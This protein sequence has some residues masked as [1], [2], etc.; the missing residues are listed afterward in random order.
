M[1]DIELFNQE[2]DK[3][4]DTANGLLK[5]WQY[6]DGVMKLRIKFI[7]K[8]QNPNPTYAKDGDS[9]FDLRANLTEYVILEPGERVLIP[10]GLFF[11][12]P[13]NF[14]LQVRSR[15]GLAL[16]N[17]VMVLNSP[18]TVDSGYRGE[19]GVI[20]YNTSK[21][22]FTINNGDRIAQAVIAPVQTLANTVFVKSD[23]LD[24]SERDSTGFGSSGI[25]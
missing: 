8:S 18:G 20:L 16:K 17:G 9:G 7:N 15:S 24:S 1:N 23:T 25:K 3:M 21:D 5:D 13:E 2:I 4:L 6:V 10:T 22:N 19:V 11:Q 14:E 12:I